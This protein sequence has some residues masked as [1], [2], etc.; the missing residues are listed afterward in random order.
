MVGALQFAL[1]LVQRHNLATAR[2]AVSFITLLIIIKFEK[3]A[4]AAA[5]DLY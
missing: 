2:S 5:A 1:A 4:A 3:V